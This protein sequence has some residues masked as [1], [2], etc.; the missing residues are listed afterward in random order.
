MILQTPQ[1]KDKTSMLRYRLVALVSAFLLAGALSAGAQRA[2]TPVT[3]FITFM[4]NIQFSP[5]YVAI[6]KGYF[7]Q[8]GLDVTIQYGDEPV[9]VNLVA[10]NERPFAMISGEQVIAA[11]A[12]GRP[13]VSVYEWFQRYPIGIVTSD[14]SPIESVEDLRGRRIGIPGLFGASYTGAIALL[15][16]NGLTEQDVRL[17][18]I[19]FNAPQVFCTGAIEASVVYINNEPLQIDTLAQRGECG[20]V[21][22]TRV[23]SVADYADMVSNGII[24]S[25]RLIAENPELVSGFVTAFHHALVD[26]MNNPAEAYLLTLPYVESLP[27]D[28]TLLAVLEAEATRLSD[29]S[30]FLGTFDAA[31]ARSAFFDGLVA[32]APDA[33]W[34]QMRVLLSTIALWEAPTPGM[35]DADSWMLTQDTLLGMRLLSRTIDVQAAFTND[36]VPKG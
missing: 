12:N 29:P 6:E 13:V 17:D 16:A 26:V 15:S 23:F 14:D 18:P 36:F 27:R 19:G 30:N 33:N 2:L 24:T 22:G 35:S 1:Y 34:L 32:A 9:G 4:P 21:T 20:S 11:R 31:D 7:T 10:A 5:I 8:A 25:E 28:A 3:F